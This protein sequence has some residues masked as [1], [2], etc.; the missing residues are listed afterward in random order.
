MHWLRNA[1]LVKSMP[2]SIFSD[3]LLCM[4]QAFISAYCVL[5][6]M[7]S[8]ADYLVDQNNY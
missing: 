1:G 2:M 7:S 5:G 6:T 8:A 3:L 4:Q